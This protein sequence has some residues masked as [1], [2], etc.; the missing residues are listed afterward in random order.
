[1]QHSTIPKNVRATFVVLVAGLALAG[2]VSV[3][4]IALR[5]TPAQPIK[6]IALLQTPDPVPRNVGVIDLG[7]PA[8]M[9][10]AVGG[11]IQ[12]GVNYSHSKKFAAMLEKH[13]ALSK[14]M[15][16]DVERSLT[17]DGYVVT[18]IKPQTPKPAADREKHGGS[19]TPIDADA[20]LFVQF[21]NVGYISGGFSLHYEPTVLVKA[22]LVDE[23]TKKYLYSRTFCVGFKMKI[24]HAVMLPADPQFRF[25]SF[26]DLMAH[27]DKAVTGLDRCAQLAADRIGSD[28]RPGGPST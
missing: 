5:P 26:D 22:Q 25:S 17:E 9:F 4:N 15:M 8:M 23:Q 1:M 10:G 21:G 7:G 3:P 19:G 14:L 6:R 12:G 28:L 20:V 11:L 18:V 2:C 27:A 13:P 24:R 16:A